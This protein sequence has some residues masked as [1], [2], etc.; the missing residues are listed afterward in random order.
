MLKKDER[1]RN[2][3][4]IIYP[5]SAPDNWQEVLNEYHVKTVISPIHDL[6]I[7][8]SGELKKPHYHIL[9]MFD[10]KKAYSQVY[11]MYSEKLHCPIPQ[12]VVSARGLVRYFCHLDNPEKAQYN[13][14]DIECYGGVDIKMLLESTD[15]DKFSLIQ[16][17]VVFVKNNNILEYCD[18][19][20]YAIENNLEAWIPVLAE[21]AY[22][23]NTLVRSRKYRD[24][25]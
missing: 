1:A 6:D 24:Y 17:I 13:T 15:S 25:E 12:K 23:L 8:K 5:D 3:S 7:N 14:A 2:W 18:I 19:W 16:Q 10:G 21:Y 22:C 9:V 20:D 4:F 11:E